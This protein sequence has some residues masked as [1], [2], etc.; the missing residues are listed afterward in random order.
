MSKQM[1]KFKIIILDD[2]QEG[3]IK[4]FM[5]LLEKEFPMAEIK[6][7]NNPDEFFDLEDYEVDADVIFL[8]YQPYGSDG[9]KCRSSCFRRK[10]SY[11]ML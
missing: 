7:F 6:H 10:G 9:P 1:E 8:E 2:D 4:R 11:Q 5:G 3:W